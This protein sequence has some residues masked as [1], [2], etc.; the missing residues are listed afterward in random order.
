[1]KIVKKT[2]LAAGLWLLGVLGLP[3][4]AEMMHHHG[5]MM[6][7]ETGMIMN[8]NPDRLPRDCPQISETVELTIRAGH[9]HAKKFPGRMFA[10]DQQEWNVKP[11][12]KINITF[13]NDDHVRHQMMIHGLPGYLYPEG[14][15]HLELF[16]H[17]QLKA[18]MIVPSRKK[19]YLVHCELPQH[20]EK[21]MK[22]QLKVDGGDGDL[23]S[24][25]GLTEPV[26]ADLYP[27]NW[28]RQ[29]IGM[30]LFSILIG[31]LAPL[32]LRLRIGKK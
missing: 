24:I 20:Q 31:T 17:G 16:G 1:M 5:G 32:L 29:H 25:P 2:T 9:E 19:T 10:Y 14:M 15:L 28:T 22:A 23:P 27:V 11:C 8:A 13:I 12:A 4:N 30:V 26:K 21:G 7:D 18:S 3:A 6:M